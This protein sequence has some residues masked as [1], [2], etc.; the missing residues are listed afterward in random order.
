MARDHCCK[1]GRI[2]AE[3]G[4][5]GP[6][7]PAG[8]VDEYLV[9]RW[10]GAGHHEPVGV[11]SLADWIN[12]RLLRAVYRRHDRSDTDV[13]L[14]AEYEALRGDTDDYRREGVVAD[15]EADGIDVD[16]LTGAFVGKS[17]VGRHLRNCL[18]AAKPRPGD[19][20]STW[21]LDGIEHGRTAFRNKVE[22]S[23]QS[24][25][26][27]DRL[28]GAATA[29]LE[30]PVLLGCP[31]CPARVTFETA[32][33]RGYVCGDHPDGTPDERSGGH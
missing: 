21:E 15:L 20:E 3:Y 25:D 2:T 18:D 29:V 30:T 6:Q 16:A 32:L 28:S 14:D 1:V 26:R 23:L 4:L 33:E 24:L 22:T 5:S 19:G 9:A 11:R 17:T 31:H 7:Q 8:D 12:R 13:R 10:T 27:K